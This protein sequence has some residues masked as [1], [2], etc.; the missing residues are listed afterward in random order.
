MK[1]T[2]GLMGRNADGDDGREE[3]VDR[4]PPAQFIVTLLLDQRSHQRRYKTAFTHCTLHTPMY[5]Y[6]PI[7]KT[8]SRTQEKRNISDILYLCSL[9]G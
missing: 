5:E 3:V 9:Y 8:E 1:V 4:S 2:K 7:R 6:K